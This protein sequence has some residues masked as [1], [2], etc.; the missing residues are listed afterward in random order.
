MW[1][2]AK[3]S[4]VLKSSFGFQILTIKGW[5]EWLDFQKI[6]KDD[7]NWTYGLNILRT[8]GYINA[9]S[10]TVRLIKMQTYKFSFI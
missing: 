6:L 2:E 9:M 8:W 3:G 4:Y 1:L 10:V 5:K 7:T